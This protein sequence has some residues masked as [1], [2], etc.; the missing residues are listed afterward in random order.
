MSGS[1]ALGV[2]AEQQQMK[3]SDRRISPSSQ[4]AMFSRPWYLAGFG[5]E[6]LFSGRVM[7]VLTKWFGL[8][9]SF[10]LSLSL[11]LSL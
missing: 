10:S 7:R 11:T 6:M 1:G 8:F 5:A 9:F 4:F 2:T 3:D